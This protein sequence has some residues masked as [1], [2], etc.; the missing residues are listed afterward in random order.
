[1]YCIFTN[2]Q[3][4]MVA[5][6]LQLLWVVWE[7]H[8]YSKNSMHPQYWSEY[9]CISIFRLAHSLECWLPT[10]S[11]YSLHDTQISKREFKCSMMRPK[12]HYLGSQKKLQKLHSSE[13][14][15]LDISCL[16][17]CSSHPLLF[18]IWK[19]LIAIPKVEVWVLHLIWVL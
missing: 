17:L 4:H 12:N 10:H 6:S 9:N 18:I 3:F 15:S 14:W 2:S 11:T 5:L 1:M 16:F 13:L 8:G 19:K 7:L